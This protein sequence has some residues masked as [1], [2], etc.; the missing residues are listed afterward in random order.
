MVFSWTFLKRLTELHALKFCSKLSHYG[1]R[2]PLL[3]WINI[4]FTIEAIIDGISSNCTDLSFYVWWIPLPLCYITIISMNEAVDIRVTSFLAFFLALLFDT[5]TIRPPIF[6]IMWWFCSIAAPL[7]SYGE[8][9]YERKNL[10]F[11][12]INLRKRYQTEA[13]IM[14]IFKIIPQRIYWIVKGIVR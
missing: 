1:I 6:S 2:G 8:L 7:F 9:V 5:I 12:R 4:I 10:N 3:S 11:S 14:Q 13:V